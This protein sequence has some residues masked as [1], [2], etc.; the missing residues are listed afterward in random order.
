MRKWQKAGA[1]GRRCCQD[2]D[3]GGPGWEFGSGQEGKAALGAGR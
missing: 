3:K 1:L 2:R